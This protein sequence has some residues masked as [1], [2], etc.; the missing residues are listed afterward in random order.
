MAL[1][2]CCVCSRLCDPELIG[3]GCRCRDRSVSHCGHRGEE[4]LC[5]GT[6]GD[7]E[8]V[9]GAEPLCCRGGRSGWTKKQQ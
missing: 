1:L 6:R 2:Q 4:L 3:R 7:R 9:W 8:P 5:G